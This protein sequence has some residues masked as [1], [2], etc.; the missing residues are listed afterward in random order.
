MR[1]R[2]WTF[3]T[4]TYRS[5]LATSSENVPAGWQTYRSP[6]FGFTI[7]YPNNIT[8][9]SGRPD[10]K[11]ISLLSYSPVCDLSTVACF[12]YNG[13]EYAGT[14]FKAAGLSVNVLR[15][16]RTAEECDRIDTGSYPVRTKTING[17]HFHYG[18][19]GEG[20]LGHWKGGLA[21][22]TFHKNVCFEVAVGIAT[23]SIGVYEPGTMK[24]FDSRKLDKE[25]DQIVQT[26]SFTG[27]VADGPGWKVYYDN[28]CGG[29][30]E[31]PERD[32]VIESIAYSNAK[33]YSNEIL[34][35]KYFA[36]HGREYTVVAKAI[37]NGQ[38][39]LET[40]LKS[41]GYPGLSEAQVVKSSRY[42]TQY[43]AGPYYY[44]FGQTMLYILSVSNVAH[45]A[46]SPNDDALFMHL[47]NSFKA[48]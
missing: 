40:W 1:C 15:D 7:S 32:E 46:I 2:T 25:F 43:K 42:Y 21:Y 41:S 6:E 45:Q 5:C 22:R 47:L 44:I 13:T 17:I 38:N 3:Y 9:Y 23:T 26:L 12:I 16:R 30:F 19:T 11:E 14:N 4:R 29:V 31:Y 37:H 28:M 20:S 48:N 18:M 24:E 35:S 10:Y 39:G 8:F 36:D 27:P 34:C 33:V